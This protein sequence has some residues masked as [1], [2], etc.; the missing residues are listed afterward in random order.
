MG[1]RG[2]ELCSVWPRRLSLFRRMPIPSP[3]SVAPLSS[4]PSFLSQLD[5]VAPPVHRVHS[6]PFAPCL[7]LAW[8]LPWLTWTLLTLVDSDLPAFCKRGQPVLHTEPMTGLRRESPRTYRSTQDPFT[9]IYMVIAV[10]YTQYKLH[11]LHFLCTECLYPHKIPKVKSQ[12]EL[13]STV[14]CGGG[15]NGGD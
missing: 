8:N 3:A 4:S 1:L 6:L 13:P 11:R 12:V 15:V 2:A 5:K 9:C 10:N 7:S 14:V